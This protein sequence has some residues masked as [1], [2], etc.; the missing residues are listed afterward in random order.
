MIVRIVI[1][2]KVGT[3]FQLLTGRI[4][5]GDESSLC[6]AEVSIALRL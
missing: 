2:N 4:V 6:E 1:N 3:M 5:A